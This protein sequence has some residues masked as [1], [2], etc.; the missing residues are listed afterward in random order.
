LVICHALAAHTAIL[1]LLYT[2]QAS[3][4]AMSVGCMWTCLCLWS[5]LW[6]RL[7][8]VAGVSNIVARSPRLPFHSIHFHLFL[9]FLG[10][11]LFR[12]GGKRA[13]TRRRSYVRPKLLGRAPFDLIL[14]GTS[15]L[16]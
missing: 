11:V 5:C 3:E 8:L 15:L 1:L 10:R 2:S 12:F 13:K 6:L 16:D 7:W 14:P 4:I 9:H